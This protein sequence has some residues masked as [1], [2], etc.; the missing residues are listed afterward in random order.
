MG[1]SSGGSKKDDKPKE[2]AKQ[3]Y[4]QG[5]SMQT[6]Q[7][8]APGMQEMLA[9]QLSAGYGA[10]VESNM[11]LLDNIYSPM[12]QALLQEPIS[13]TQEAMKNGKW[14]PIKTGNLT[15]DNLLNNNAVG[16][17]YAASG[18]PASSAAATAASGGGGKSAPAAASGGVDAYGQPLGNEPWRQGRIGGGR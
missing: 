17:P 9:Q 13:V 18:L 10:P 6:T 15:L 7:P 11:G 14:N 5:P 16:T 1:G 8:F 12:Q 2:A 3:D 4:T